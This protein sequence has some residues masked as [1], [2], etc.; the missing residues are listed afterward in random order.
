MTDLVVNSTVREVVVGTGVSTHDLLVNSAVRE[1]IV[2][3]AAATHDLMVNALVREVIVVA[4]TV[5]TTVIQTAVTIN[6]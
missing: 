3:Q 2:R 6:A 4:G 1:V 5:M